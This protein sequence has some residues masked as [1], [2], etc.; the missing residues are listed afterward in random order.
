[1][2]FQVKNFGRDPIRSPLRRPSARFMVWR[3]TGRSIKLQQKSARH[4]GGGRPAVMNE[5]PAT[6]PDVIPF[7]PLFFFAIALPRLC[8]GCPG[9]HRDAVSNSR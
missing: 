1:M 3:F 2:A 6:R 5:S 4:G 8:S 7:R 9:R